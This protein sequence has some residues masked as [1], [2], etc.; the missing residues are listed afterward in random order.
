MN[1]HFLRSIEK[2]EVDFLVTA[3]KKPW[4]AVEVKVKNTDVSRHLLYFKDK[5]GIPFL[6]QVVKPP[7]FDSFTNGVRIVS[8]DRFLAGLI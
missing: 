1:V 8:A 4:F 2:K 5:V 7:G 3:D 6:Y